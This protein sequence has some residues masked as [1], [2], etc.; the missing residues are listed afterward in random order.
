M[1]PSN[2]ARFWLHLSLTEGI[3]PILSQ[4]LIE[5]TGGIEQACTATAAELQHVEGIG[6]AKSRKIHEAMREASGQVDAEIDRAD[7]LG[8]TI[9]CRDDELF[10][11]LLRS[12]P[13]PPLVLYVK[14][15]L[16]PRDLN[17]L[18]I[19]G[20]RR[21]SYYGREQSE[22]FAALLAGAGMTVISGGARGI[23]SAAHR[24]ALSHP[25]G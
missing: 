14:G 5:A 6:T 20:S 3:G 21:C 15:S 25:H 24:G 13:D 2:R 22:R 1:P 17:S 7:K 23:D 4:R 9:I 18:A 10:P 16:E 12:I 8:V 19:V 11:A